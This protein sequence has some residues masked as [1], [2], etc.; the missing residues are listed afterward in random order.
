MVLRLYLVGGLEA[1][2]GYL[3]DGELLVVGLLGTDDGGVGGQGEVDPGVRH[4]VRL[5]LRQINVESTVEPNKRG[6]DDDV[7]YRY[8]NGMFLR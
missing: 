4:Q 2:V 8:Y 1:S 7:G 3:A 5:K 6:I